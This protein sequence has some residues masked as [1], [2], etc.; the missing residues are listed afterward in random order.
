MKNY[1]ESV[2]INHNLTWLYILDHTYGILIVCGSESGETNVLFNLIKHQR[3]D[4]DK[5]YL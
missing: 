4:I 3:L 5:V 1:D 2:E